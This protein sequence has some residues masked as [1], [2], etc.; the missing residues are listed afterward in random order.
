MVRQSYSAEVIEIFEN[1]YFLLTGKSPK[2]QRWI[3]RIFSGAEY[4]PFIKE[5]KGGSSYIKATLG[6]CCE[7]TQGG[8]ELIIRGDQL[9]SGAVATVSLEAGHARQRIAN[10]VQSKS[11]GGA[12][13]VALQETEAFAFEVALAHKIREYT[14]VA[15]SVFPDI[16]GIRSYVDQWR[17][18]ARESLDDQSEIQDRGRLFIWV[19]VLHDPALAALRNELTDNHTLS[20]SSMLTLHD[21]FTQL[22]PSE[23]DPYI[24]SITGSVS[25]DLNFILGSIDR[26]IGH[27]IQYLELALNVPLLTLSP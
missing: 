20:A 16:P 18:V 8:L 7:R 4:N 13:L 3:P 25:D 24:E 21:R 14:G 26:R 5:F 1:S 11:S 10:P 6:F 17:E 27:S 9:V 15:T 12:N 19:A 2:A 23:V 22:T